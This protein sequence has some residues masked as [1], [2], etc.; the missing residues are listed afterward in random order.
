MIA[1]PHF[2]PADAEL[3]RKIGIVNLHDDFPLIIA[4]ER[5]EG[6]YDSLR[7]YWLPNFR[8][9]GVNV[10]LGA[11]FTP[12]VYVPDGALRHACWVLDALITEVEENLDQIE[13]AR[14][15]TDI[16]RI[17]GQGKVAVVVAFEGMEPL[18]QDLSVL[19]LFLT[20]S[21]GR[22][23][24]L[25]SQERVYCANAAVETVMLEVFGQ[26]FRQAEVLRIRP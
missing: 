5:F 9:G 1:S 4:K 15:V 10:V 7:R 8:A 23:A 11:I 17:N 19:R 14:S 26:K 25:S 18:G 22:R 21:F 12:T 20:Q 3:T 2:T 16:G 24:K 13:I 6:V